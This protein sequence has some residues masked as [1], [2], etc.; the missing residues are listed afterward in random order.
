MKNGIPYRKKAEEV[1]SVGGSFG[2]VC[3][4]ATVTETGC[5]YCAPT[6]KVWT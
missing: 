5:D 2:S 3:G 4:N 6:T 1:W